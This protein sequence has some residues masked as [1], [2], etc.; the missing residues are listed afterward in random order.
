VTPLAPPP[1]VF[2]DRT[3]SAAEM[4]A[5]AWSWRG[6]LELH[7]SDTST[8]VGLVMAPHPETLALLFALATFPVPL[9]LL[10]PDLRSWQ[11]TPALPAN[12][13]V[14]VP[15][16]A[17]SLMSLR[18]TE[19]FQLVAAP[20]PDRAARGGPSDHPRL[21]T[22][23]VVFLTSGS[24]GGPKPVYRTWTALLAQ[25]RALN[26]TISLRSGTG[27]LAVLPLAGA[28][29]FVNSVVQA[30]LLGA[31][32]G[33]LPRTDHRAVLAAF[34]SGQYDYVSATPFLASLLSRCPLPEV[35]PR[36]PST[37]RIAGGR[38]PHATG[39]AFKERFGV[40][41]LP[42]YGTTEYGTITAVV[43]AATDVR[44]G[45]VG[46]PLPGVE[47]RLGDDPGNPLPPG[48]PGQ[49]WIQS[50]WR[51]EGYGCPPIVAPRRDHAGWSPTEDS[52]VLD[53]TGD[54]TL[55]G[56]LDECFKASSGHL[57]SPETVAE[58]LVRHPA[59]VDVVVVPLASRRGTLIGA[60][61]ET[62]G[63]LDADEIRRHATC[64]LPPWAQPQIVEVTHALPRLAGG[65][66]DRRTSIQHLEA[67]L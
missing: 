26:E 20:E 66:P 44:P 36:A 29:G 8:P 24:T 62:A 15:P 14:V 12:M 6:P 1:V 10:A 57:V 51:M 50:P 40:R 32:L 53:G 18:T 35:A 25:G 30:A 5:L 28:Q 42:Q 54:L 7:L 33:L 64:W 13:K 11:T 4:A 19:R 58:A 37:V 48:I 47:V 61:V 22:P 38:V 63:A 27:L 67:L 65:K 3:W 31:P 43:E 9:V 23:G 49:I 45:S 59:V 2:L 39:Q 56:R 41:L 21:Q 60:L 55:L 52:G 17:R 46:R 16:A 34:A